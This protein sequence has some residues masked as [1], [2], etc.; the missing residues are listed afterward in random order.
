[1][2]LPSGA[3]PQRCT[4]LQGDACALPPSQLIKEPAEMPARKA[5][6]G[7]AAALARALWLR[8]RRKA[9]AARV[10]TPWLARDH[11]H[12]RRLALAAAMQ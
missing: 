5:Q 6:R 11:G 1:V 4:F 9:V 7:H 12:C 2:R 3:R 8:L 10:Q